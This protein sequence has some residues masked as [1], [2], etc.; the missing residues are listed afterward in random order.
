MP[1]WLSSGKVDS[2][3]IANNQMCRRK[4]SDG[5][6]WNIH[7]IASKYPPSLGNGF[8]TQAIYY[9][10]LNCGMRVPPSACPAQFRRPQ[11]RL[12][13]PGSRVRP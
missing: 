10:V 5:E 8:W 12:R 11:P 13:A 2:I 3:G 1:I 6:A 9:H 7:V 4:M